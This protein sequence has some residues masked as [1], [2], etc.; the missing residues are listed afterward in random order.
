MQE[1]DGRQDLL[2]Q[3]TSLG[4]RV[5]VLAGQLAGAQGVNAE[6]L[7][8]LQTAAAELADIADELEQ[9]AGTTDTHAAR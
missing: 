2:R 7:A 9:Y 6:R 5:T 1:Q 4:E 3:L 8:D